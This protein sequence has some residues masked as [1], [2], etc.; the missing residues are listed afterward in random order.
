[1]KILVD[2]HHGDLLYSLQLLFEK[3]L[4]WEL[5]YPYG[6]EWY[7]E[8]YWKVFPAED[9]ARQ[10]LC[11][12]SG[13]TMKDSGL[14]EYTTELSPGVFSFPD[15]LRQDV[16]YKV[17]TLQAFKDTKFDVVLSSMPP[18]VE[19]FNSLVRNYQ[20]SAKHI[21]QAGNN[22]RMDLN[23]RNVLTSARQFKVPVGANQ[24]YY[25]QEFDT[26]LFHPGTEPVKNLVVNLQ[27]IMNEP[28]K[29]HQLESMMPGWKFLAHGIGNR[30]G[31]ANVSI[32]GMAKL[33]QKMGFLWHVKSADEGYGYNIHY[34]Y[35]TGTP[36]IVNSSYQRGFT[37]ELLYQ[38]KVNCID[39]YNKSMSEIEHWLRVALDNY[40]VWS[41][42]T[43]KRFKQV[44]DFDAEEKKIRDF[45]GRLK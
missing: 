21:F 20:P 19:P 22:W 37:A 29:F 12:S 36:L 18:H 4:G 39:V 3:R 23:V 13:Q 8:G 5:Y 15:V 24:V 27:H 34:A 45:L 17:I 1:M 42:A 10:Y 16:H 11:P 6:I 26:S 44:V 30:D 41:Q 35:A 33:F 14:P 32:N 31:D 38:D 2:N 40:D 9:T 43:Y 25:H 28:Q 7:K